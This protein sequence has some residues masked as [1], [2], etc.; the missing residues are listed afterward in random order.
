M[1]IISNPG[2]LRMARQAP[3]ALLVALAA[4]AAGC[5]IESEGEEDDDGRTT[6]KVEGKSYRVGERF[7]KECNT[8]TCEEDGAVACTEIGCQDEAPTCE[9]QGKTYAPGD[10]V[11]SPDGCNTCGCGPDGQIGCTLIACGEPPPKQTCEFEGKTY[12][13]GDTFHDALRCNGCTCTAQGVACTARACDPAGACTIGDT[14][15]ADGNSIVCDDG[16][17]SC[18][19]NDGSWS[20]TDA[21]CA[22]LPKVSDCNGP[23]VEGVSVEVL[24]RKGDVLALELKTA[25]CRERSA[26]APFALCWDGSFAESYPVQTKV[27]VAGVGEDCQE[28]VA[29]Q[30][31]FDL[32]PLREAYQNGYQTRTGEISIGLGNGRISY[33]F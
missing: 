17:N 15:I 8:C 9:Y 21:A 2:A 19:C 10:P 11:P 30:K 20:S 5:L 14:Q 27:L 26:R 16:C 7:K 24:Y 3:W 32:S 23:F 4:G 6:C 31:V 28:G 12:Q 22:P 13:E 18:L 33:K 1:T 29:V 25:S